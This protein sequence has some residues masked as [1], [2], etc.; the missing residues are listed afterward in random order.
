MS[1]PAPEKTI[2]IIDDDDD[3]AEAIQTLLEHEGYRVRRA[4]EGDEGVAM[5]MEVR[6]DLILLDFM[7]PVKSGFETC[8][9]LRNLSEMKSVPILALTAYG[10]DIGETHGFGGVDGLAHVDGF[11]EKPVE[12]NVLLSR[13]ATVL[14]G[15]SG[16]TDP[17]SA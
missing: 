5:A 11:L 3:F 12:P 15:T 17:V 14:S 7:M 6:P 1:G 2:L 4:A 16:R 10:R 13:T 8:R 9:E